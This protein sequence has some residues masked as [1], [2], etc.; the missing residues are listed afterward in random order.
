MHHFSLLKMYRSFQKAI[1]FKQVVRMEPL[2]T[3]ILT[4]SRI[5]PRN[6]LGLQGSPNRKQLTLLLLVAGLLP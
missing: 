4:T 3:T 6:Q 1:L 5:C 2:N